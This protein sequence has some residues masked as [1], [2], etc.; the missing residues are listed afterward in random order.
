MG[1]VVRSRLFEG[2]LVDGEGLLRHFF[3][4]VFVDLGVAGFDEF[5]AEFFVGED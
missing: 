3:P 1:E 5:G 4:G 2:F